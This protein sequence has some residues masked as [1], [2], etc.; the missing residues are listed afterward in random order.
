[1]WSYIIPVFIISVGWGY[2]AAS[3][4]GVFV[5][6][7]PFPYSE[8]WWVLVPLTLLAIVVRF[9]KEPPKKK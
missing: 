9:A 8:H 4:I 7:S 2:I 1:M 6:K 3:Y 5:G